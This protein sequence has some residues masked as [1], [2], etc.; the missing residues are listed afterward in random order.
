M[1]EKKTSVVLIGM[2]GAGKSTIG[3]LLAKKMALDFTDTDLLIQTH[4]GLALQDIVDS[5]G[6][7]TLRKI[8]EAVILS[9]K[10]EQQVIATG[11][12]AVYSVAA[13]EYL[14]RYAVTVFLDV[15]LVE[16]RKRV[17]DFSTRGIARR[18]DQTFDDVF[19]ERVPMYQKYADITI[20]CENKNQDQ[21]AL[22]I[23]GKLALS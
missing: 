6:Y 14:K 3:V 15:N 2:P 4:H 5:Q 21:I 16:I 13:M 12:S 23:A 20:D 8:E 19:A 11:G 1:T 10:C 17:T 22:E 7:L 18:S 9:M